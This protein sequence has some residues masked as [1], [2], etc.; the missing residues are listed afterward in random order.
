M[1]PLED[2]YVQ[3]LHQALMKSYLNSRE[4]G[5]EVLHNVPVH[6]GVACFEGEQFGRK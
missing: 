2:Y 5:T 6:L 3:F 1:L 4:E